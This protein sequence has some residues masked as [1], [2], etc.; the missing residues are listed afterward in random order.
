MRDALG[1]RPEQGLAQIEKFP[2][3]VRKADPQRFD[4][5]FLG[6]V[7]DQPTRQQIQKHMPRDFVVDAFWGAAAEVFHS[8]AL[9]SETTQPSGFCRRPANPVDEPAPIRY[10][11]LDP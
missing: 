9:Q 6:S 3:R 11:S 2:Q 4:S 7:D 1:T 10:T 8:F 5:M